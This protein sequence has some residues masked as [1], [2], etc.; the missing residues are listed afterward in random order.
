MKQFIVF[1]SLLMCFS[2][3]MQAQFPKKLN[4]DKAA[5]AAVKTTEALTL[6]DKQIAGYCQEY[7]NW[8]DEHNPLCKTDD[9]DPGK[10]EFA[11][12]LAKI[13]ELVPL[14]EVNG[15]KLDI[16]AYY[17]VDINA[18]SCANGSIRVFAGL[19]EVMSDDEILA[20][21]GHEIGHLANKDCKDRFRT[22]L[23]SSALRDAASSTDG[24]VSKLNDTQLGDLAEALTNA[25]YSQKQESDAD[26]YGYGF[27]KTCNKDSKLMAAS[28]G[29]LLKLQEEAGGDTSGKLDKLMSSHPDLQK[30]ITTLNKLK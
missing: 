29:V 26:K 2:V 28:L 8:M 6:T 9:S 11:T 14:K 20:V 12:R 21:I 16:Q 24:A 23:L 10:K 18:F 15:L 17:V 25:Q 27:L 19:M 5:Q 3:S 22:A 13:V 4:V 1:F 30:R 7:I